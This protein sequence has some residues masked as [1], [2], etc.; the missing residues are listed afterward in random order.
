[1]LAPVVIFVYN[2]PEH[3]KRTIEALA[4][5]MLAKESIVYIFSDAAKNDKTIESVTRVRNYID[6]IESKKFFKSVQI[7]KADSNKGL[8]KSVIS[9]V[10]QIID[11]YKNIIVLE[12]DLITSID[13][14]K[15]MNESLKYYKDNKLIWSI[16]GYHLPIKIPTNYQDDIYLT[17][18][19]CSWGWATWKN[20]WDKVDWDVSDYYEFK[21]SIKLKRHF[22]RGG[23]D[24][25]N[26][27]KLQMIG[28]IDSWAIR[29]C[30][31]QS[32]LNMLTVYPVN[33]KISNEGCDGT[34]THKQKNMKYKANLNESN[35][36]YELS[37]PEL[38]KNIIRQYKFF[39]INY[40][41]W[42]LNKP[43][44]IIGTFIY[45]TI[46]KRL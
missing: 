42:L 26:M 25:S 29:W 7:I 27:L 31:S 22:N 38:N 6:T 33:S 14:L 37:M 36:E 4:N 5:N 19:G 18:R 32:K 28:E 20:R 34:G 1:M 2:R 24:L 35:V 12:D 8:A 39:Y 9:G 13:F 15:Y 40:I 43:K 11:K 30:Y 23:L 46:L 16:T 45:G 44:K 21:R 17:Y 10:G 3:T 41:N